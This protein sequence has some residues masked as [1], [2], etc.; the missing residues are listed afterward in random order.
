M[1]PGSNQPSAVAGASALRD[2]L[3]TI[4]VLWSR[5]LVRFLRQPTRII[6]AL[7][8]P[9]VFWLLIGGGMASTFRYGAAPEVGYMQYFYPGILVM[10]VLFASIFGTITVIED[11]HAGFLQSVLVG[12]GSRAAVVIGKSIGVGSVGL[13]QAA[14]FLCLAPAAGFGLGDIDWLTL[15]YALGVGAL[16]LSAFGFSLAWLTDSTQAYHAVMSIVLLPA[17]VLSGAM[18]PPSDDHAVLAALMRANPMSYL[19]AGVRHALHVT[20]ETPAAAGASLGTS[21]AVL[22]AFAA[23]SVA[24]ATFAIYRKR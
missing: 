18:F 21:L 11:R 16:G 22:T 13:V 8:Q 4:G 12:P 19:V 14:V 2:D 7:A 24:L 6:G 23:A 15:V 10:M 1:T 17:W 3:A 5:D 9:I 20:G